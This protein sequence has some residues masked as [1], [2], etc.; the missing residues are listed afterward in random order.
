MD[1][2]MTPELLSAIEKVAE[3]KLS[4]ASKAQASIS[5]AMSKKEGILENPKPKRREVVKKAVLGPQSE[6]IGNDPMQAESPD[7][8]LSQ[9]NEPIAPCPQLPPEIMAKLKAHLEEHKL[10]QQIGMDHMGQE[11]EYKQQISEPAIM[12]EAIPTEVE[13]EAAKKKVYRYIKGKRR[14]WYV[15]D[16][17]EKF[18]KEKKK[19]MPSFTEQDRPEKVKDIYRALKRDHPEMSAEMK[20]RIAAKQGKPGKQKQGPPYEAPLSKKS[21]AERIAKLKA[22][23]SELA[24][25]GQY[26]AKAR[27]GMIGK[28][29][30]H[31]ESKLSK[32]SPVSVNSFIRG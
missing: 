29:I 6:Y 11:E 16:D 32:K 27:Q 13:K 8:N 12:N 4:A 3:S 17:I 10:M 30:K 7:E 15:D 25:K 2:D 23:L 9:S 26:S 21:S 22:T 18:A 20:A 24:R 5:S 1:A 28:K 19:D 14:A 31:L